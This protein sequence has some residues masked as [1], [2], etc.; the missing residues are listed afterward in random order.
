MKSIQADNYKVF[1]SESV[2]EEINLFFRNN[3]F[4]KIFV[5]VDENTLTHCYPKIV[6]DVKE[7]EN[8]EI[9]ELE[10][11]E[12]NKTIEVCAQLWAALEDLGADRQSLIV[13]LGGG[14][15]CDLGGFV[16]STFKRGIPF[17]NIPTTLLAQVDASVGGKVGV[18]L[19]H[20]KNLVGVFSNPKAVFVDTRFLITLDGRQVASGFAEMIK[21]ALITDIDYWSSLKNANLE[22]L[23]DF[24]KFIATSVE[25]KNKVVLNDPHEKNI[26]KILNFGHT[27]G[28]AVESYFLEQGQP[29]LHGE[30]VAIGMICEAY[31][32][33]K[34][35]GLKED[36]V[37]E[38]TDLIAIHFASVTIS[39]Q[40]RERIIELMYH[41]KKNVGGQLNFSMLPVIGKC[42]INQTASTQQVI[43][44]L[45]YYANYFA[46]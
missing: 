29:I 16:A 43:E 6:A 3:H 32:S 17:I 23:D 37:K 1:I 26:R 30:A 42:V 9:I 36:E 27:I 11:G 45:A 35:L 5:F 44:A 2:S 19:N 14:L 4:S 15:I 25:I 33:S 41:D 31:L 13:N 46:V 22:S 28:H 39:V 7:L 38:I 20:L 12:E 40:A 21:H 24:D 34:I 18:D 10:S 8:A